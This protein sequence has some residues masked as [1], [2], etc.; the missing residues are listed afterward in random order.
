MEHVWF[1]I[2]LFFVI[3]QIN[4]E[5]NPLEIK[6]N[7]LKWKRKHISIHVTSN[8]WVTPL[9]HVDIIWNLTILLLVEM[10]LARMSE[11]Q[12]II[13][14]ELDNITNKEVAV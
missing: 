7:S 1:I 3:S 12:N 13:T 10:R 6:E 2:H 4:A 5:Y 14:S 8:V 9:I 11:A